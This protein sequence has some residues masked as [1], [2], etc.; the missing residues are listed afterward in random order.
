M[1]GDSFLITYI[2]LKEDQVR[3]EGQGRTGGNAFENK[4]E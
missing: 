3:T 4:G 1:K 2:S